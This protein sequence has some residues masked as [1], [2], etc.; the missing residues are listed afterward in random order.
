MQGASSELKAAYKTE[1]RQLEAD[2]NDNNSNEDDDHLVLA[3][4]DSDDAGNKGSD[5]E[6]EEGQNDVHCTKVKPVKFL[7]HF[8]R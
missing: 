1:M 5:D 7:Y 3:D 8:N 4:Y 2:D 6:E